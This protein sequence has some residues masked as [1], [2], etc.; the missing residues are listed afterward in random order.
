MEKKKQIITIIFAVA[1]A[2][3]ATALLILLVHFT[4]KKNNDEGLAGNITTENNSCTDAGGTAEITE[5]TA[6]AA[7][8]TLAP[9]ATPTPAINIT[10]ADLGTLVNFSETGFFYKDDVNLKLTASDGKIKKIYYTLDSTDPTSDTGILY[11]GNAI[12]LGASSSS[13]QLIN[14]YTVKAAGKYEDGTY[15]PVYTHSY[16]AGTGIESR[17]DCLVFSI[18]TDPDGIYGYENGI[19]EAGKLRDDYLKENNLTEAENPTKPA[20]YNL[21]GME[22]ERES[23]LEVFD[24]DGN[25]VIAQGCGIRVTGA[26][27]RGQEQKSIKLFA[28]DKYQGEK[29]SFKYSFFGSEYAE[30]GSLITKYGHLVLRNSANDASFAFMRE[31]VAQQCSEDA[32]MPDTQN[33]VPAAVFVNG[34]YYGFAWL[35]ETYDSTYFDQKYNTDGD[36]KWAVLKGTE[37]SKEADKDDKFETDALADYNS[38]Y[39][40]STKDL[41]NDTLYNEV[42]EKMDLDNFLTYYAIE[43]YIGNEDWPQNNTKVYRYYAKGT[44]AKDTSSDSGDSEDS[45]IEESNTDKDSDT[46]KDSS[47]KKDAESESD[48]KAKQSLMGTATDGKW[49]WLLY[50]IEYSMELYGD[51]PNYD[52]LGKEMEQCKLLT[53]LLARD[54][55]KQMFVNKIMELGNGAFSESHMDEV[56]D[57]IEAE[58]LKEMTY[59]LKYSPNY[60]DTWTS[61]EYISTSVDGIRDFAKKR[62]KSMIWRM[63]SYLNT[64]RNTYDVKVASPDESENVRLFI[65]AYQICADGND[66][67]GTFIEDS[68]VTLTAEMPAGYE[69]DHWN[70]NGRELTGNSVT[71]TSEDAAAEDN[72]EQTT[73]AVQGMLTSKSDIDLGNV[74]VSLTVKKAESTESQVSSMDGV[75]IYQVCYE[76]GRDYFTLKNTSSED[77]DISGMVYTDAESIDKADAA[78]VIADGTVLK[79]GEIMKVY[80]KNYEGASVR[81]VRASFNLK[82][83]ETLSIYDGKQIL[84]S[85]VLLPKI[86]TYGIYTRDDVTGEYSELR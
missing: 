66:Y 11:D 34:E 44:Y 32:G 54:D 35:H 8:P 27:S 70:V 67:S 74:E 38:L 37:S 40:Y 81:D 71:I 25:R 56:I 10:D 13:K 77:I 80:C 50:D 64:S 42:C 86:H 59:S 58:R 24:T 21:D 5:T 16:F 65:G 23:Y 4:G 76:A 68:S 6:V 41:T 12:V 72:Q 46:D 1:V 62:L 28:R 45:D 30:D 83:Y 31:E 47:L 39:A 60:K 9:T 57:S 84:L 73:T 79:A 19:F 53:A 17:F 51:S 48:T 43:A 78:D 63:K 29:S 22:S 3:L 36:G 15:T 14:S 26:W 2:V 18:S 75:V 52:T 85:Q 33:A 82:H 7:T 49:R 20:N 55:V 61:L 69:V